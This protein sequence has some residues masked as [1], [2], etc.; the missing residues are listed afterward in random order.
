M[1]EQELKAL[2]RRVRRMPYEEVRKLYDE[3]RAKRVAHRAQ[4]CPL[5]EYVTSTTTGQR[6]VKA[7]KRCAYASQLHDL[8]MLYHRRL[9]ALEHQ[10]QVRR[11]ER[12][13]GR[14]PQNIRE[15]VQWNEAQP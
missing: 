13:H 2:P 10:E 11:F 7:W 15:L 5:C 1:S 4:K 8:E 14:A 3:T 6:Q 9:N 12:A